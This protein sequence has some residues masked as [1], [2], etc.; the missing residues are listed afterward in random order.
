MGFIGLT[1]RLLLNASD[2][3]EPYLEDLGTS[4]FS[5][6]VRPRSALP[7]PPHYDMVPASRKL[8]NPLFQPSL[9]N[10]MNPL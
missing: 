4:Q 2:F 9:K 8:G 5:V 10:F 3:G 1:G 6:C 7:A